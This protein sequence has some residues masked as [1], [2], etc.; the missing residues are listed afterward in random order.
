MPEKNFDDHIHTIEQVA[1]DHRVP[2]NLRSANDPEPSIED[3][4]HAYEVRERAREQLA[5][6]VEAEGGE[7]R[8]ALFARGHT[9]LLRRI[10]G[11]EEP[12]P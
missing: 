8:G 12:A 2:P 7:G 5:Q 4:R 1:R 11:T 3:L 9:R 10:L 6:M